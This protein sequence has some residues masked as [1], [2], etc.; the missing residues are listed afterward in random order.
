[1]RST[2]DEAVHSKSDDLDDDVDSI[3]S[4]FYKSRGQVIR[5]IL[6]GK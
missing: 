6:A 1:M 3:R 2:S 5:D 4:P